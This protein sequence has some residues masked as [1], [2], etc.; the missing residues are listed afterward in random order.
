M[1]D[2]DILPNKTGELPPNNDDGDDEIDSEDLAQRERP[3]DACTREASKEISKVRTCLPVPPALGTHSIF[4]SNPE[5]YLASR[6]IPF[7]WLAP[8][9]STRMPAHMREECQK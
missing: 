3:E 1:Y 2:N 7:L 8:S 6:K 5:I 4:A 9:Y